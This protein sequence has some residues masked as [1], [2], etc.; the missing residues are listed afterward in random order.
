MTAGPKWK[1]ISRLGSN[2]FRWKWNE[3][4]T[5]TWL[6]LFIN[7]R[8]LCLLTMTILGSRLTLLRG[9]ARLP[10]L[11]PRVVTARSFSSG[12]GAADTVVA[13]CTKK[14]RDLLNPVKL[15]VTSSN[16][17]PNGSH[18]RF[19]LFVIWAVFTYHLTCHLTHSDSGNLY[20][21]GFR[22]K[23]HIATSASCIQ[24]IVGRTEWSSPCCRFDSCKDS[25]GGWHVVVYLYLL[26]MNKCF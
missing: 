22:R 11:A 7:F 5:I 14:I 13:T 1:I 26:V 8:R 24:S 15:E 18:V 2:Q 20:I 19:A 4:T 3:V 23:V 12:A 25:S 6:M 9:L 21:G 16:D 10:G 17:D